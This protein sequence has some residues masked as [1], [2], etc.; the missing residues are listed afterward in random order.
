MPPF[1]SSSKFSVL[2]LTFI[3]LALMLGINS[4]DQLVFPNCKFVRFDPHLFIF[5]LSP[6][7]ASHCPSRYFCWQ[8]EKKNQKILMWAM[9]L[10]V[11]PFVHTHVAPWPPV[12]YMLLHTAMSPCLLISNTA[13][14]IQHTSGF[15]FCFFH[16][17]CLDFCLFVCFVN[18]IQARGIRE[19]KPYL[20]DCL[21]KITYRQVCGAFSPWMSAM[22]RHSAL[23]VVPL[24]GKRSWVV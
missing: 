4:L 16:L 2:S 17:C 20:K 22:G 6:A 3:P 12:S 9:L 24:L 8:F 11:F 15:W 10:C 23:S 1:Y 13:C 5:S 18:L 19:E 7:L 21:H 14:W